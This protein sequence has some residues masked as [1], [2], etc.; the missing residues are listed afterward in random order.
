[1]GNESNASASQLHKL[2]LVSKQSLSNK[3]I[4][5]MEKKPSHAKGPIYRPKLTCNQGFVYA[6]IYYYGKEDCANVCWYV[7]AIHIPLCPRVE[8][9]RR[10]RN[11]CYPCDHN[12][13]FA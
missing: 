3:T 5:C 1:M 2:V 13:L 9:S 12:T 10:R 6:C 4:V 8:M 11:I 7:Y